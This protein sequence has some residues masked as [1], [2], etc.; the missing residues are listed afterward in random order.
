V[1]GLDSTKDWLKGVPL[2]TGTV[3][4]ELKLALTEMNIAPD[5]FITLAEGVTRKFLISE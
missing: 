4:H 2:R 3:T 5:K 1:V